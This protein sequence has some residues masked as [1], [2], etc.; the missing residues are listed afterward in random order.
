MKKSFLIWV[1]S[2]IGCFAPLMAQTLEVFPTAQDQ[3]IF[4]FLAKVNQTKTAE[5]KELTTKLDAQW[6][7]GDIG[8]EEKDK[9]IS[10]V[11]D[12]VRK[13]FALFPEI[14]YY[15]KSF[16]LV[17]S[18]DTYV[19]L[20]PKDFFAV[21]EQC[22]TNLDAKRFK[23]YVTN[24]SE[25]I[26]NGHAC[27][28]KNFYWKIFQ[29]MP[30]IAFL[31]LSDDKGKKYQ[32]PI[33]QIRN[34]D[35]HYVSTLPSDSTV[36]KKTS[37]DFNLVSRDYVGKGGE[38]DWSKM[39]IPSA[40]CRFDKLRL[41]FNIGVIIVDSATFNYP[42][43]LSRPMT[44]YFE[45]RNIGYKDINKAGFPLFRS[46]GGG[47]VIENLVP[48]VRYEGGFSM[49]GVRRVGS[50]YDTLVKY[51]A[52]PKPKPKPKVKVNKNK[53]KDEPAPA[54]EEKEVE[55]TIA[56]IY[57]GFGLEE[58]ASSESSSEDDAIK[59]ESF[60]TTYDASKAEKT[61]DGGD[62][63]EPEPV[64]VP[65]SVPFFDPPA[66]NEVPAGM[67]Q[68]KI[69]AKVEF[70]KDGKKVIRCLGD[71][72]M[73][74]TKTLTGSGVEGQILIGETD[75]ISHPGTDLIYYVGNREFTLKRP[76]K[77]IYALQ[78]FSSTYHR[79]Y[80][81]FESIVWNL[82]EDQLKFTAFID[83]ENK[84]AALESFDFFD[85]TRFES[86]RGVM[87]LHPVGVLYRYALEKPGEII[88][89]EN[90][91]KAGFA[92]KSDIKQY[93][94]ILPALEGAG[95]IRYDK[96][97]MEITP[98]KRLFDW[99][100]AARDKKDYDAVVLNTKVTEGEHAVMHMKDKV[101]HLKGLQ[102]F[103]LSDSQFVRSLPQDKVADVGENRQITYGGAMAAGK[104]NFYSNSTDQMHFDYEGY[105]V[106]C[107][108]ID[109]MRFVL[110]RNAPLDYV[111]TPLQIALRGTVLEKVT[112]KIHIDN[113]DNKNSKKR[114]PAHAVFDSYSKSFIYW[115][116]PGV[117]NAIYQKE[118]LFFE[119]DPFVLDS[120]DNFDE[121]A[122]SFDG[123]FYSSDIF[124][125]FRDTLVVMPDNTLGLKNVTPDNGMPLYK[126]KG[127]FYN[128]LNMDGF[129]LHANGKIE[130]LGTTALSDTFTFHFDSVMAVA[131]LFTLKGEAKGNVE[132][133]SIQGDSVKYRW[134]VKEDKMVLTSYNTPFSVYDDQGSF[135]GQIT[136]TPKGVWGKGTITMGLLSIKGDSILLNKNSFFA[137]HSIFTLLDEK[138][139]KLKHFVVEDVI[140][141]YDV[142]KK[143]SDFTSNT[144]GKAKAN[145]P[146]HQYKTSM[147]KGTF[148]QKDKKLTMEG[149]SAYVQDD[150][151]LSVDPKQDSL[152]FIAKT[153]IYTMDNRVVKVTGVPHIKVADALITPDSSLVTIQ[154]DGIMRNLKNAVVQA[155]QET[156][157]HRIYEATV[158]IMSAKDY[159]GSG[160]YD[161]IAIN[162]NQP[163][164]IDFTSVKVNKGGVTEATGPI[165]ENKQ[166][167]LTERI[168]FKGDIKLNAGEKYM[169]FKGEVK[170]ESEN[171]FFRGAWLNFPES[172]VNPDSAFIPIESN[173]TNKDGDDLTAG[174]SYITEYKQFYT[175]FLQ[176]KKNGDDKA[177]LRAQ[178][179][180]TFD[181]SK[182]EFRIG[183]KDKLTG[184]SY[185]GNT[186][187]YDDKKNTIAASGLLLFPYKFNKN[188][189]NVKMSG[190]WKEDIS[191]RSVNTNVLMAVDFGEV[192]PAEPLKTLGEQTL[193]FAA[194][195]RDVNYQDKQL[196][197]NIS[198][199]ADLG[200]PTDKITR[201]FQEANA[202]MLAAADIDLN[203]IIPATLL[204]SNV[205]FKANND[206]NV[207]YADGEVGIVSIGGVSINKMVNAKIL[208]QFP[209]S[210]DLENVRTT[211]RIIILFDE[212]GTYTYFEF[213]G[214]T[215][216]FISSNFDVNTLMQTALEKMKKRDNEY[217]CVLAT[218]EDVNLFKKEF[219]EKY[220]N[221]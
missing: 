154:Q 179:G 184:K 159:T 15:A 191:A 133:P 162:G 79:F 7:N 141:K 8:N 85:R 189:A 218:P 24:L 151:F 56:D 102:P 214:N 104:V 173:P 33:I 199:I 3:F 145:F 113:P 147:S 210:D 119:L 143:E 9:F 74:D 87:S 123:S 60:T 127:R 59:W 47:V 49:R 117:Q 111:F 217:K 42:S 95:Y 69:P 122:L 146:I 163:Q 142:L 98:L 180:L 80:L 5:V 158:N 202:E 21:T 130:Y 148:V 94:A 196:Y 187:S 43:V 220:S 131:K 99:T 55:E 185:Q 156:K 35:L 215:V 195:K 31:E 67:V 170:I 19:K 188:T 213:M 39:E 209:N 30:K 167:Y 206:E 82:N 57:S 181:R 64:A 54:A 126:D 91:V 221:K 149:V 46:Y 22:I 50:S 112:G 109:S 150:Y 61:A 160:K 62:G 178:G 157:Y 125:R 124:P 32:A 51:V 212:A 144:S 136:I 190:M 107:K 29:E 120:L 13:K 20:Q 76:R 172:I 4:T 186:V 36:V 197:E 97:T 77:G 169:K 194:A 182:K 105:S 14:T 37:G 101:I 17:K 183:P 83:K 72:F 23:S 34:A 26:P 174:L 118:K 63:S 86:E 207:L 106:L 129:G 114:S 92:E 192:I 177:V 152:Q 201:D 38:V 161:Y 219:K 134:Y 165:S 155:N 70:S 216:R 18:Q 140:T 25:Y 66:E 52:P 16:S 204:L 153:S 115:Q 176:P 1:L 96:K 12:M 41:N 110:V 203:K 73:L 200:K 65:T 88:T 166:F 40:Y 108:N 44:G 10:Q 93:T 198:A 121:K 45:D 27:K 68:K 116:K 28:R 75:T 78:P 58:F 71:E 90:I 84:S 193:F 175:T 132:Y 168:Q 53:G 2:V 205:N 100:K 208:Y 138:D 211:D 135:K 171:P 128:E 81:Y 89:I 164:V 48:N 103:V 11:N 6:K 137:T 139:P